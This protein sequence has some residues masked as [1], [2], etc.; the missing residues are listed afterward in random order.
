[1]EHTSAASSSVPSSQTHEDER[2][3]YT[4][5]YSDEEWR[6]LM[7]LSQTF[8]KETFD[9]MAAAASTDLGWLLMCRSLCPGRSHL[10]EL[11]LGRKFDLRPGIVEF[12][13]DGLGICAG[14]KDNKSV[15]TCKM[16]VD[17]S[18]WGSKTQQPPIRQPVQTCCRHWCAN[19]CRS[20]LA[21]VLPWFAMWV[22]WRGIYLK[23][24]GRFTKL[25]SS[26]SSSSFSFSFL[27]LIFCEGLIALRDSGLRTWMVLRRSAIARDAFLGILCTSGG[28]R[29]H[30]SCNH[31]PAK[32]WWPVNAPHCLYRTG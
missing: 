7:A 9:T 29:C 17:N 22:E 20:F 24:K 2:T 14:T 10:H 5:P 27:F 32:L 18:H 12:N 21:E 28:L 1:M 16:L 15:S 4:L 3:N 13:H 26:S 11:W 23:D 30:W 31:C 19:A 25:S 6:S 8:P